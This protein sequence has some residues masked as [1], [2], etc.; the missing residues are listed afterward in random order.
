MLID[1]EAASDDISLEAEVCIVGAGAAGVALARDLMNAGRHVCL[2]EAGGMD[3]DEQTQSLTKGNIIG[4]EYYDL[5]HSRLRFF[6]GTTNIWGGRSIP[7]DRIDFEKR[8]WVPHSGWP[9]TLDD[10]KPYYQ[11][12][13]DSLEL[14]EYDYETG[15]WEKLNLKPIDFDPEKIVHRFWRFDDLEERFNSR[16]S[17]DLVKAENVSIVLHANTVGLQA[18]ENASAITHLDAKTLQGRKLQ[19]NARHY[20]LACGAIENARLLLMSND[21]EANG[22]GNQYDQ[23]GRYFMEHPHGRIAHIE[24]TDPAAFWALVPQTVSGHGCAGGTGTGFAAILTTG[25][26]C[27]QQCSHFQDTK[28]SKQGRSSQQTGL[29]EPET[30]FVTQ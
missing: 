1:L 16:R 18:A 30:Q 14:G 21:V 27:A 24:T 9:I 20:V 19:V 15:I 3:Y 25:T 13:H 17:D 11:I 22:I 4:M 28:R 8:D 12:A 29:Y 7:L 6:G 5:D 23:V 26:G 10:L 2:L